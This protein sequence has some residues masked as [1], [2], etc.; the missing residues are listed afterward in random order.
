MYLY[1]GADLTFYVTL[2]RKRH[3]IC[4]RAQAS[5]ASEASDASSLARSFEVD[6]GEETLMQ[7]RCARK[8]FFPA[9]SV[10]VLTWALDVPPLGD[11]ALTSPLR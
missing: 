7:A 8:N 11:L 3:G 1:G 4:V 10:W 6:V 9:H 2:K 5:G